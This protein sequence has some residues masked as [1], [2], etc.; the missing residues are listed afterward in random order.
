[1]RTYPHDILEEAIAK[2]EIET[3]L[4]P[5]IETLRLRDSCMKNAFI[6]LTGK[7]PDTIFLPAFEQV[8]MSLE[9]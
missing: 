5:Q 2:F 4:G 6:D 1:M 8:D 7:L 3:G 9:P